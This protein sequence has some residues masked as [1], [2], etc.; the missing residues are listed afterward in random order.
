MPDPSSIPRPSRRL[1]FGL[2]TLFVLV[3]VVSI[4]TAWVTYSLNWIQQRHEAI[5]DGWASPVTVLG[6][7]PRASAPGGLWLLGEK[8][9]D[10]IGVAKGNERDFERASRLFPEAQIAWESYENNGVLLEVYR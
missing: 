3:T 9:V 6:R 8:G 10:L 2:R 5:D 4:W 7:P 1:R